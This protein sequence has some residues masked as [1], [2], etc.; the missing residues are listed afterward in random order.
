MKSIEI[1][2]V[3]LNSR[4]QIIASSN[5]P[6][7]CSEIISYWLITEMWLYWI[8]L[9]KNT[10]LQI[11][12]YHPIKDVEKRNFSS[13]FTFLHDVCIIIMHAYQWHMNMNMNMCDNFNKVG[14]SLCVCVCV[15]M[16]T[17]YTCLC[18]YIMNLYTSHNNNCQQIANEIPQVTAN[19]NIQNSIPMNYRKNIYI[20][21]VSPLYLFKF[22]NIECF[23]PFLFSI[24]L[25]P[26]RFS[27]HPIRTMCCSH[28]LT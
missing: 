22:I 13:T 2:N 21:C 23:A 28:M 10:Y 1:K 7:V 16:I 5:S 17:V 26:F 20:C 25:S 15:W 8:R 12:S 27:H 19:D 9:K 18:M 4:L 3:S 11:K 14:E 24:T 6:N